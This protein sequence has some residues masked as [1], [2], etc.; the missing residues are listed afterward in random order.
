MT[1]V[2]IEDESLLGRELK[3]KIGK[4]DAG[5]EILDILPSLKTARKW[6]MQHAEPDLFFMDIQLG[7]GVSFELFREFNLNAPV[8][9]TT[10]Y[11]E[12]AIQAFKANGI[13]YLQKPIDDE[14]LAQ[15][16]SKFR[17]QYASPNSSKNEAG[18]GIYKEKFIVSFRNS[19]IPVNT[20][21]VACFLRDSLNY[22][23]TRE[24]EKYPIDYGSLDEIEALLDPRL[25]FRANRQYIININ[26]IQRVT[27]HEN[28]KLTVTLS[29]M[30]KTDIDISK[31]KSPAFRKWLD[32]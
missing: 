19:W 7:D 5:I 10:A 18:T 17:R 6:L 15:A 8:I 22:L 13:D 29:A 23:I 4:I 30:P 28:Q 14:E 27:P 31:E 9:F 1:A 12:F 26:A 3:Y 11:D 20:S 32:R 25:F 24:A 2:I 21:Q 16:I